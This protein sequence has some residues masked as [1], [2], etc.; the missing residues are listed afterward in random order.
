MNRQ[1]IIVGESY[2]SEQFEAGGW[3]TAL[4][5]TTAGVVGKMEDYP[6]NKLITFNNIYSDPITA[7]NTWYADRQEQKELYPDRPIEL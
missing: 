2:Y 4:E 1:D 5:V 6:D 7:F 3:F